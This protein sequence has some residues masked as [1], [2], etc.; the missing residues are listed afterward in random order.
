MLLSPTLLAAV[1]A[2][3]FLLWG[4]DDPNGG[5]DI[6]RTEWYRAGRV[7]L[8]TLRADIDYGFS[9]AKTNYGVI[10]VKVW[11]FKGEVIGKNDHPSLSPSTT[12]AEEPAPAR[13]P[14][15]TTAKTGAKRA[16]ASQA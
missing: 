7:P 16:T 5:A 13:K 2:P 15:R 14:R 8:L 12:P 1:R 4:E 11:V 3:V 10:G 6:A 9:E